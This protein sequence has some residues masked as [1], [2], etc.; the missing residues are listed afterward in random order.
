MPQSN[1][2][3]SPF[4]LSAAE[5]ALALGYTPVN[6]TS[7]APS[8][9]WATKPASYTAGQP[10]FISDI[11]AKGSHW[12]WDGTIY[13]PVGNEVLL[14][15]LDTPSSAVDNVAEVV[16]HQILLP[17]AMLVVGDR[18]TV[19][20]TLTKSG[21][22]DTGSLRVRVG[23]A[24]TIA[25]SAPYAATYL[26]AAQ[27]HGGIL[28]DFKVASATTTL[29]AGRSDLGYGGATTNAAPSAFT[30]SNISGALY[31]SVGILAGGATNTVILQ[32]SEIFLRRSAN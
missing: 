2:F 6:P 3:H 15:S 31:I 29:V 7:V 11:G 14:A 12:Y 1:V 16:K 8:Y 23:T 28:V 30:I 13:K 10:I 4:G 20:A 27:Q 5:I 25:D 21:T 22:T 24:G 19:R 9:T 18:I 32:T 17:A 26:S